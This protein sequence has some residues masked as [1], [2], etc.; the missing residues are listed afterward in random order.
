[1]VWLAAVSRSSPGRSAVT[2]SRGVR[3]WEA[4]TTAGSRFATAV[5]ED[6]TTT[7]GPLRTS[8]GRGSAEPHSG[9]GAGLY[10]DEV[11]AAARCLCHAAHL[12]GAADLGV[13][14]D[15]VAVRDACYISSVWRGHCLRWLLPA[16]RLS[17][18]HEKVSALCCNLKQW[19]GSFDLH[20]SFCRRSP[21]QRVAH[22]AP[23]AGL[24]WCRSVQ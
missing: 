3:L 6:V 17:A 7:A 19:W 13:M 22:A 23:L 12:S 2:S 4:S 21:R 20:G 5:P 16:C 9:L 10:Q 11:M 15:R 14:V 8:T 18:R 1:M 24:A